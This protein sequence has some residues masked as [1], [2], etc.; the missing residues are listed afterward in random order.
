MGRVCVLVKTKHTTLVT[1]GLLT[2]R[3]T[4]DR[5]VTLLT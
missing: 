1:N 5:K 4:S 3:P 2:T